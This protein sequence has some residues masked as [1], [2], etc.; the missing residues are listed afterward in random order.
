[1][2]IAISSGEVDE[3][4]AA[5]KIGKSVKSRWITTASRF[6]RLYVSAYRG[7]FTNAES[8]DNLTIIVNFIVKV[9]APT[10]FNIKRNTT[11]LK[12]RAICTTLFV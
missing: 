5:A 7:T 4:L 3:R 2:V 6:L 1:M 10:W 12:E 9:Y 8:I 11:V